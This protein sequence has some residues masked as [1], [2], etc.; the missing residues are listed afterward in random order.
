[1]EWNG[2][3][4]DGDSRVLLTVEILF[5]PARKPL[6]ETTMVGSLVVSPKRH[7]GTRLP[8]NRQTQSEKLKGLLDGLL[9][10]LFGLHSL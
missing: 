8:S 9:G 4:T 7:K 10:H 2:E 3:S 1:M 6:A 5:M